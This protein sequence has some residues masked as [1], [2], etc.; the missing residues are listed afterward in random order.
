MCTVLCICDLS[1]VAL[2]LFEAH[3]IL[4]NLEAHNII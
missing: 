1:C 2:M 3:I 4:Y